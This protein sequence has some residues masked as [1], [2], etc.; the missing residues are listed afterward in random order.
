MGMSE[1]FK[2]LINSLLSLT[3]SRSR[4]TQLLMLLPL[5]E[6]EA[7]ELFPDIVEHDEMWELLRI[8]LGIEARD[9]KLVLSRNS[10]GSYIREFIENSFSILRDPSIRGNISA[11]VGSM[12]SNPE[13]EWIELRLKSV[14]SDEELG[15]VV[16][17]IL[18]LLADVDYLDIAEIEGKVQA[19][20]SQ[21]R[22]ALYVLSI[23]KII[24]LTNGKAGIYPNIR[25][26]YL[27]LIKDLTKS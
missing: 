5:S 9:D 22:R 20:K 7:R 24:D 6:S 17:K 23:L 19:N 13:R 21:I 16:K 8:V 18:A 26:N 15:N 4:I 2:Q 27:Q 1:E 14:V 11:I 3:P 10:L 12:I 25:R